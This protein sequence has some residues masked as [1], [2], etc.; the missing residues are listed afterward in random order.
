MEE[1]R[2]YAVFDVDGVMTTGQFLYSSR[3]K[4]FKVFGAHDN[5]GLK[6]LSR[7]VK[8]AFVTA[9][10]RGFSIS[11]RRI[12]K[13]MKQQLFLVPEGERLAFIDSKFGLERVF[14]MGDGIFDVEILDRCFFGIC[15]ANG[16]PEAKDAAKF[17]TPSRSGEGAVLDACLRII[18]VLKATCSKG[19]VNDF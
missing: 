14:Y 11:K 6:L 19:V 2:Y 9:D 17:V 4:E 1:S 7:E 16:R 8:V 3:G 5:D 13:D 12:V 15:P 10:K 18:E